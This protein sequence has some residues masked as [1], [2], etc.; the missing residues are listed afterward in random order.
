MVPLPVKFSE[1]LFCFGDGRGLEDTRWLA[2]PLALQW[3]EQHDA[4]AQPALPAPELFR[5]F[6]LQIAPPPR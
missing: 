4:A 2:L 5:N 3:A 6:L 1:I